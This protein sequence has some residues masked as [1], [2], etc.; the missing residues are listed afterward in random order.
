MS[1]SFTQLLEDVSGLVTLP[2]VSVRVNEMVDDPKYSANDIGEVIS[3]DPG[4]TARLLKIANSPYYGLSSTV[5]T[6]SRAVTVL[7]LKQIRDLVLATTSIKAFEGIP[8]DLITMDDF[9]RHNI[10]CGIAAKHLAGEMQGIDKETMFIA[11][12]LHD[13]GQLIIF[14]KLPQQAMK[15]I[16]LVEDDPEEPEL[17]QAETKIMGFNHA[18]L[19]QE[20]LKQWHLPAVFQECVGCHHD[21]HSAEQYPREAALIHISNSI[22]VMAE[23]NS[24]EDESPAIDESAWQITQLS[25]DVI[26]PTMQEVQAR[27]KDVV[28]V[29]MD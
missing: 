29:L 9:W 28:Q 25:K 6:V 22:A 12:L 23:L 19:G 15:A 8:N 26:E 18:Q 17:Y 10:S 14:N 3:Q 5:E 27:V 20:L 21:I 13:I 1:I 4:L 24:T 16:T 7:G 11:G 2:Q